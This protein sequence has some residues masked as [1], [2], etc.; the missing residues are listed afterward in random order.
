MEDSK[1]IVELASGTW[2]LRRMDADN[3][4]EMWDRPPSLPVLAERGVEI[5]SQILVDTPNKRPAQRY[6]LV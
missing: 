5:S 1:K 4:E 3:V 6:R 2:S